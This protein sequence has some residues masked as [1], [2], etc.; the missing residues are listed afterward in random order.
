MTGIFR[1]RRPQNVRK[2]H[3]DQYEFDTTGSEE[4]LDIIIATTDQ[5]RDLADFTRRAG[6]FPRTGLPIT[7]RPTV[8]L[9]TVARYTWALEYLQRFANLPLTNSPTA[10]VLHDDW[11]D[12]ELLI[13]AGRHLIWY[14][15]STTA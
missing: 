9:N 7:E 10:V 11:D 4:E 1:R 3:F 5:F 6:I 12:F 14:H 15:W 2:L 8:Q 13:E